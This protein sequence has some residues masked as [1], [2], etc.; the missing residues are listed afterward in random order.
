MKK[1]NYFF[2]VFIL[3]ILG[4]CAICVLLLYKKQYADQNSSSHIARVLV[5]D[6][7]IK[8]F[9]LDQVAGSIEFTVTNNKGGENTIRVE[10]GR[11]GIIHANCPDKLCV[12][13]GFISNSLLPSVCLPNGVVIDIFSSG[14]TTDSI[15][16]LAE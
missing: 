1:I 11:I 16:T 9:D 4:I 14:E 15:D 2:T 3:L 10:H 13:R 7:L 8:T 5:N 12:K 6:E